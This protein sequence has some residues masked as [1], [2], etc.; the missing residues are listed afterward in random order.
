MSS[1][2]GID[3]LINPRDPSI[4]RSPV[5][6]PTQK[7]VSEPTARN[8]HIQEGGPHRLRTVPRPTAAIAW[9]SVYVFTSESA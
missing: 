6:P 2:T 1:A 9:W 5:N 7:R 3:V 8:P 4:S